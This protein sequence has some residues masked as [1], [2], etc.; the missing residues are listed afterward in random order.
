MKRIA[1]IVSVVLAAAPGMRADDFKIVH[2]K[3]LLMPRVG[4]A[5]KR[6]FSLTSLITH[7]SG[8]EFVVK[9]RYAGFQRV[10]ITVDGIESL[11]GF[12]VGSEPVDRMAASLVAQGIG[13]TPQIK[14]RGI[15]FRG[16]QFIRN[17]G[18]WYNT[19]PYSLPSIA[20]DSQGPITLNAG[21][22]KIE[23]WS[24]VIPE[25]WRKALGGDM[26]AGGHVVQGGGR[27]Y[28]PSFVS[29]T[30]A[31]KVVSY[32]EKLPSSTL[33]FIP[34]S[35]ESTLPPRVKPDGRWNDGS[36]IEGGL[37]VGD[38]VV[39]PCQ[40]AR[41]NYSYGDFE[42][43][44]EE[45]L[46][47]GL[48]RPASLGKTY[49]G[50][51][52]TDANGYEPVLL[53]VDASDLALV[54]SGIM[55]SN[56]VPYKKLSLDDRV[57]DAKG[58]IAAAWNPTS[59]QL[60]VMERGADFSLNKYDPGPKIHIYDVVDAGYVETVP[61]VFPD[62]PAVPTTDPDPTPAP[63]TPTVQQTP[64]TQPSNPAPTP[65]PQQQP[66]TKVLPGKFTVGVMFNSQY[67]VENVPDLVTKSYQYLASNAH[68]TIQSG[69]NIDKHYESH[70]KKLSEAINGFPHVP[71]VGN[72]EMTAFGSLLS[73]PEYK[74][75]TTYFDVKRIV[76]G[77][78]D[79][80]QGGEIAEWEGP[81]PW[82]T[83]SVHGDLMIV[84]LEFMPDSWTRE[85]TIL[86]WA[87]KH[88]DSHDGPVMLATHGMLKG[89]HGRP[90]YFDADSAGGSEG[91][92][93][94]D[95]FYFR[96]WIDTLKNDPV[97]ILSS[98]REDETSRRG[99][100]WH[101]Q[102]GL[103]AKSTNPDVLLI[104]FDGK[105]ATLIKRRVTTN[106]VVEEPI[107]LDLYR[108]VGDRT[109]EPSAL[110]AQSDPTPTAPAN[111]AVIIS[112]PEPV[113]SPAPATP[114]TLF[115]NTPVAPSKTTAS[116]NTALI[117]RNEKADDPTPAPT[118]PVVDSQLPVVTATPEPVVHSQETDPIAIAE[119]VTQP[120]I[121]VPTVTAESVQQSQLIK[122][123]SPVVQSPVAT[124]V[125]KPQR[126][127]TSSGA[128][129]GAA[130]RGRPKKPSARMGVILYSPRVTV[131]GHHQR[132]NRWKTI[133][134]ML[135]SKSKGIAA[136]GTDQRDSILEKRQQQAEA[137]PG[138]RSLKQRVTSTVKSPGKPANGT[139]A[140]KKSKREA[141]ANVDT[142]ATWAERY[143]S[144]D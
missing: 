143:R 88:I 11:G 114:T 73:R 76:P 66:D 52:G 82:N 44:V 26:F 121:V 64:V 118:E 12:T 115:T 83:V 93:N 139:A 135:G 34:K 91:G 63:S 122:A 109:A 15:S 36:K 14:T 86:A 13:T 92:D 2:R 97:V 94:D 110:V 103:S 70:W 53:V 35:N 47:L 81:R 136:G 32:D 7:R 113:D 6:T 133:M 3:T 18:L 27:S 57:T 25:R 30:W 72:H 144:Y 58:M 117:I 107:S 80:F 49:K 39:F 85:K 141:I 38:F 95:M 5:A 127:A 89:E 55:A 105:T 29:W 21:M 101:V 68:V 71:M 128:A 120:K 102:R 17:L 40:Y 132:G 75:F 119:P 69:D 45:A 65:Q 116:P 84:S 138:G 33:M 24:G 51:W 61:E 106:E 48:P 60:I 74:H 142:K 140:K 130:P 42:N 108:A 46:A 129:G 104:E 22:K 137:R 77:F 96:N 56:K 100:T 87:R 4:P 54:H 16:S 62:P 78:I 1:I 123:P 8:D 59:K 124:P 43:H 131:T 125:T 98:H 37:F 41:G 126:A 134:G 50:M 99:D 28:G 31:N 9:T 112:N 111:T 20:I 79:S 19:K 67:L 90:L 10:R 23:G